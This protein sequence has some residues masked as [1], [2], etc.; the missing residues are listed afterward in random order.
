MVDIFGTTS[1]AWPMGINRASLATPIKTVFKSQSLGENP[2]TRDRRMKI[3]LMEL[4]LA[5]SDRCRKSARVALGYL[6]SFINVRT[7]LVTCI[8]F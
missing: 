1:R 4:E 8:L 2:T 5:G 6:N 3:T 7:Y